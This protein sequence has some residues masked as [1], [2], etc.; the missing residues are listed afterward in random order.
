MTIFE[1]R[2]VSGLDDVEQRVAS[3]AMS[4]TSGDLNLA[5]D[6]TKVQTVGIRFTGIDIP[7]GA[8]I[9]SAYLQFQVDE[10]GSGATSLLVRGEDADDAA[11]F[12][13]VAFNVSSRTKTDA[14]ASWSPAAW[15]TVGEAGL[16]QRTPDL[17]AIVQEIVSR[18]GWS[19]LNDMAFIITG[20]GTRTAES[21]EGGAAKAPLLHIEY[22]M[23]TGNDPVIFNVPADADPTGDQ[24]AQ[25]AAAGT[26]VGITASAT[27]PDTG[28]TVTY[29]IDDQRFAINSLTGEI[30]RSAI[31][32]LNSGT[33]PSIT[34]NVTATSSDGSQA[35][36]AFTL[37]V[38]SPGA[39]SISIS[40]V[41]I[42]EGNG[43]A[44]TAT[45]TVSRTGGTAA[46]TVDYATADGTATTAGSDYVANSGTLT[47]A[48]DETT[49]QVVTVTINGDT[50]IETNE[51]FFVNLTNLTSASGGGSISDS[52]GQGTIT[53][54]D[55]PPPLNMQVLHVYNAA[56]Y[57]SGDPSG[58]AYVPN[59]TF[60][61]YTGPVLFIANSEH[62]ETPYNSQINLF[63]IRP[64]GTFIDSYS[65]RSFTREPTGLAYNP[66][67]G[68]LYIT[69]DDANK[70]FWV[71]PANPS[72]KLGEFSVSALGI[73]DAEDP[74]IDPV[75]GNIYMLDGVTSTFFELTSTGALVRSFALP[76]AITDA[77]ALAYDAQHDVFFIASGATRGAI[78][79]L[80]G[81]GHLL[82]TNT[83]LNSYLN[84]NGNAKPR[85]KGLELALSSDPNDGNHL[86]LYAA[87]YGLDQQNDG[88]VFEID[89]GPD[90]LIA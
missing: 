73:A 2:V 22:T 12:A 79:E 72:V 15:T 3:G 4:F 76:S 61:A 40:D 81:E 21:F 35:S 64:D 20:T 30:T 36:H 28:D 90:W 58:L 44:T 57:G 14:A 67:N 62:D 77:E 1:K 27:D 17:T 32:T 8:I 71:D 63:A 37:G 65:M 16:A 38:A 42:S 39:G 78:F 51:T 80:D 70:V 69:D 33:E 41:S 75:T 29:G 48:A 34:L 59:L 26:L 13:N 24:I 74:K 86:S 9:T 50:A 83:L 89:L 52:Q 88:R 19:A 85:I 84:P 7:Q 10:T 82:A 55:G 5:N 49:P 45:F 46:F 68:L 60:G 43:S 47:F 66:N 23:P 11:A 53:N 54:D 87:D 25:N 56:Q 6:G 31:G 18:G